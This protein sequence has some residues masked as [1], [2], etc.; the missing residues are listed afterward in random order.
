[1]A[2]HIYVFSGI[3]V[4]QIF[5]N[6]VGSHSWHRVPPTE[7]KGRVHTSSITVVLLEENNYIEQEL[8]PNEIRIE[9][10]RGTGN[11]GQKRNVTDSC[12][13]VTHIPT[14]VKVRRD[15]RSQHQNKVEALME[16]TKR[17]NEHHR[18]NHDSTDIQ[19]R[20]G[21]IGNSERSD[22]RRTYKVKENMV[23]DH[24]SGKTARLKDVLRGKIELLK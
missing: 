17:I 12:V 14:G 20:K 15:S 8:N 23:I 10:T 7:R 13:T 5:E 21:Q 22:K 11:G 24:I 18:T 3:N 16:L 2:L 4:K 1:M 19:D 6:E 9:T